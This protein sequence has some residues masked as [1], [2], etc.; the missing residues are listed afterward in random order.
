MLV[1]CSE[2]MAPYA[3]RVSVVGDFNNWDGR[4]HQMEKIT[5]HGVYELFIPGS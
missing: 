4:I 2:A 1:H 5:E 3:L